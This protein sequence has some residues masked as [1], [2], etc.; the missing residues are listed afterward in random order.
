MKEE[1][2]IAYVFFNYLI[3]FLI[4]A[5]LCFILASMITAAKYG[6]NLIQPIYMLSTRIYAIL[7][8]IFIFGICTSIN[9]LVYRI[10]T[11]KYKLTNIYLLIPIGTMVLGIVSGYLFMNMG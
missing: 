7:L 2:W 1:Y 11:R 3:N 5:I 10:I 8:L 6:H 4:S 9:L